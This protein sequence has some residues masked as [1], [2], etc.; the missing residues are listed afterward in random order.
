MSALTSAIPRLDRNCV[1][2]FQDSLT[3]AVQ[4]I[5]YLK[6]QSPAAA[7]IGRTAMNGRFFGGKQIIAQFVPEDTYHARFPESA[8]ATAALT[9]NPN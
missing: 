3:L 6:Y 1:L 8:K 9:P 2:S 7:A 5:V 4:G